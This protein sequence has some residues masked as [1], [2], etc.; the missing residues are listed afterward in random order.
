MP[1]GKRKTALESIREQLAKIDTDIERH[2]DKI[3]ELQKKKKE[4]LDLKKKQ[5]VESLLSKIEAS[6]KSVDEVLQAI[7][8]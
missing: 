3:K 6:G 5:E 8:E 2:Q 7:E 4:L 1:R